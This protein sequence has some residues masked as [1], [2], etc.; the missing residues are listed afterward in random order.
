MSLSAE[1]ETQ[2]GCEVDRNM[3]LLRGVPCLGVLKPELQR[4]LAY[5]CERASFAPGEDILIENELG[6]GVLVLVSGT[7]QLMRQGCVVGDVVAGQCVGIIAL[8]SE[9][10]WLFTLRAVSEA[11]CIFLPRKKILPQIMAHPEEMLAMLHVIGKCIADWERHRLE[12]SGQCA[13]YLD[14]AGVSML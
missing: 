1:H 5:L 2:T 8:V 12:E 7:A 13:L 3:Q 4:V 11:E 9:F 14:G 6:S 10:R